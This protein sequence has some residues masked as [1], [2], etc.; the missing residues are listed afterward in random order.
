MHLPPGE[1][2]ELGGELLRGPLC[3][4]DPGPAQNGNCRL[5]REEMI[6]GIY[7]TVV[8]YLYLFIFHSFIC[9]L[10]FSMSSTVFVLH[11]ADC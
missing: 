6:H 4:P 10:L 7:L 8:D 5:H 9:F 1:A 3:H 2:A 11:V